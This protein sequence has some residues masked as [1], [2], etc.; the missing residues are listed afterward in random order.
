MTGQELERCKAVFPGVYARLQLLEKQRTE[1]LGMCNN[2][3]DRYNEDQPYVTVSERNLASSI[4]AVLE[5][6]QDHSVIIE[7][8][9]L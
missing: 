2:V 7:I 6:R 8:S 5:E 1:L 3:R 9:D 4:V